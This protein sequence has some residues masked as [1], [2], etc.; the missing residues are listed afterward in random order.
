MKVS[1]SWAIICTIWLA[2]LIGIICGTEK[3]FR[4]AWLAAWVAGLL[5]IIWAQS[6]ER[7]PGD[8]LIAVLVILAVG[9]VLTGC[10][11]WGWTKI[12][13]ARKWRLATNEWRIT[14]ALAIVWV[15]GAAVFMLAFGENNYY[16]P[17]DQYWRIAKVAL[18]P[19]LFGIFSFWIIDRARRKTDQ[20]S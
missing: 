4:F 7:A 11:L 10:V 1:D 3:R 12:D 5:F 6:V 19:S 14:L 9:S 16:N 20:N 13:P 15:A 2:A 18:V 8:S 17:E